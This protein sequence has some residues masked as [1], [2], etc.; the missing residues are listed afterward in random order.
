MIILAII[1]NALLEHYN[2]IQKYRLKLKYYIN[3][4]INF[5]INRTFS[6]PRELRII[7]LFVCLP[8]VFT[9]IALRL[10]LI[11]HNILYSITQI[12]IF[13]FS[14][15]ILQWKNES[16]KLQN[17]HNKIIVNYATSFFAALFW[18]SILPFS[19]GSTCYMLIT[20]TSQNL[21]N[22]NIDS[23]IYKL[24][25]DKMLFYANLV[26]Y[27]ALCLFIA[28]AGNFEEVIHYLISER[29]KLTK[30][31]YSLESTLEE[32][33]LIAIGKE[34]FNQPSS[35]IHE[36]AG[37]ELTEEY[38]TNKINP[39]MIPYIIAILYRAEIF[40]IGVISLMGIANLIR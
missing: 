34:K 36:Q 3:S 9:L 40:F 35:I 27:L 2:L 1:I 15:E 24:V 25:V 6:N 16:K 29:P 11:H 28:L 39:K 21:K 12:I 32:A 17:S 8:V 20:I 4:Y 18:F 5:F 14:V 19:I 22:K 33:I 37:I 30:S 7:Y 31:F 38:L 23:I 13:M 10:I 26:P